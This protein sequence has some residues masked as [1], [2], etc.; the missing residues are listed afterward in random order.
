[1]K[2]TLSLAFIL[3][4]TFSVF[5]QDRQFLYTYQSLTLPKG[6]KDIEVWNTYRTGRKYAYNRLDQRIEFEVG[7]TDKLQTALYF[8]A[9][10]TTFQS[11]LD[12]L[13]GIPDT[14]FYALGSESAFS[15]SSEWKLRLSD[16]V[17]D[18]IGSA[19]YAEIT[20][21]TMETELEG[22]LI[23]DKKSGN[24][25]LAMNLVGEYELELEA[26]PAKH[27]IEQEQEFKPEVDL[28]YMRMI[29]PHFGLGLEARYNGV[30][31][32][33]EVEHS[34]VFGGP[35]LFYGHDKFF[36]ILNVNPQIANLQVNDQN[37][38]SFDMTEYE[39]YQVRLLL[40]LSF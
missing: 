38:E 23:L 19:L 36:M 3:L 26:E 35:T 6:S 15:F 18:R 28:A 24:N 20:V 4:L 29:K 17:A 14:A 37:P 33:G 13:G 30:I 25:I 40:G 31:V 9:E 27:E 39:K 5:A 16:P 32:K 10:H 21:G 8:N 2:K 22:K 11:H 1:M 7:V 12:T 34:A